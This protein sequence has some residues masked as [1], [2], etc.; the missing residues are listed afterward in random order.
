MC[1]QNE[2]SLSNYASAIS[3]IQMQSNNTMIKLS[4][5]YLSEDS[6]VEK[7]KPVLELPK[8]KTRRIKSIKKN[9]P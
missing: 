9:I 1:G 8:T 6:E 4:K 5:T 2:T 7:F 3:K